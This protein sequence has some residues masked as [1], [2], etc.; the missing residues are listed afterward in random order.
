VT[1]FNCIFYTVRHIQ[2]TDGLYHSPVIN[3]SRGH[4]TMGNLSAVIC[5]YSYRSVAGLRCNAIIRRPIIG[6]MHSSYVKV[7]SPLLGPHW[8][9]SAE[10]TMRL[11]CS[12]VFATVFVGLSVKRITIMDEFS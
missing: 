2:S 3:V 8:C 9:Y 5:A 1:Y 7:N 10:S 4:S 11:T 12:F 6:P